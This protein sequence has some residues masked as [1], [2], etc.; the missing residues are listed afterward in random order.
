M[1]EF[2]EEVR[3]Q[4]TWRP[5]QARVLSELE[6]HLD[7][8]KLH[9][10]AAPG[11]GKTVLGLEVVRRS[12]RPTL[13]LAPTLAIRDQ[14]IQRLVELFLPKGSKTPDWVSRDLLN[15]GFITVAT[16]QALHS[17]MSQKIENELETEVEIEELRE[18]EKLEK[19][20]EDLEEEEDDES[21]VHSWLDQTKRNSKNAPLPDLVKLLIEKEVQ[22]IV[23]D[24]AHHLRS[25]WWRSLTSMIKGLGQPKTLALTATPPFDVPPAEWDRYME[26]CGP[27]DA[28]VS[29]PEL[30]LEDNLCPHQDLVIFSSPSEAESAEITKFRTE[31]EIFVRNI[32]TQHQFRRHVREHKWL[33]PPEKFIEEILDE[34]E[35]F[36]SLI[37]YLYHHGEEI[38]EA[39]LE[40]IADSKSGIPKLNKE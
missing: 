29:V 22:T 30:V 7:D 11:S 26:L 40:I 39:A 34:P 32:Q 24:E 6:G 1:K 19:V 4:S 12:N 14:W 16:Y 27:V 20:E 18:T 3:F 28:R 13:I 5:Y 38:P 17:A 37:V 23:L 15:P 36:S 33:N 8:N 25:S 31:V 35:F 10:V 9:V 2:P 21:D